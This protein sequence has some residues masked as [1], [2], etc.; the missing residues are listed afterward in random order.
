M[1]ITLRNATINELQMS[2]PTVHSYT[3]NNLT[4]ILVFISQNDNRAR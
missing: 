4:S 3:V 1:L 2:G